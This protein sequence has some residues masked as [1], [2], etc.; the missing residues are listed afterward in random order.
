M[1]QIGR[2]GG[3]IMKTDTIIRTIVL[4]V[5]LVN[6]ILTSMGKNPLP[7]AEDTIYEAVTL[8]ATIGASAWSWWKNNSFTKN[9]IKADSYLAEL[10]KGE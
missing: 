7:F 3:E 1:A 6:Q 9:A 5:A 10:K 8:I 4:V 2:F